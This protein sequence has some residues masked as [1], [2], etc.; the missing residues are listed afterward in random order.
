VKG[1]LTVASVVAL[2]GLA[3]CEGTAPDP[4]VVTMATDQFV[5]TYVELRIT[6]LKNPTGEITLEQRDSV[7]VS[8]TVRSDDMI[9][10]AELHGR[11]ATFMQ[12]VWDSVEVRFS[13]RKDALSRLPEQPGTN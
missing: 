10:F 9:E 6:A 12:G 8:R 4:D 1:G 3:G 7:L 5:D 11:N 13:A 2:V